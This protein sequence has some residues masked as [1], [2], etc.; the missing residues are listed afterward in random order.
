M[1]VARVGDEWVQKKRGK[2]E[3]FFGLCWWVEQML[4]VRVFSLLSARNIRLGIR[5]SD[6]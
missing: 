4:P 1:N 6:V 2:K 5:R 3:A